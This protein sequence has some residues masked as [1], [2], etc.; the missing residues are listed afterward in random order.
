[1]DDSDWL[2]AVLGAPFPTSARIRAALR[3]DLVA[4]WEAQHGPLGTVADDLTTMRT[5]FSPLSKSLTVRKTL[6]GLAAAPVL[7]QVPDPPLV[8]FGPDGRPLVS[9]E[10]RVAIDVLATSDQAAVLRVVAQLAATQRELSRHRLHQVVGDRADTGKPAQ[11][12]AI[13]V[14]IVM[15]L[16]GNVGEAAALPRGD[17]TA[18]EQAVARAVE[19]FASVVAPSKRRTRQAGPR[20]LGGW[21]LGELTRRQD[22]VVFRDSARLYLLP[23]GE[24]AAAARAGGLLAR[25][26]RLTVARLG[27]GLDALGDALRTEAP[28]MADRGL[29]VGDEDRHAWVRRAVLAG[30]QSGRRGGAAQS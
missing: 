25:R 18:V 19:A 13:G 17:D 26:K 2:T 4:L 23:D 8:E 5:L 16:N 10:G 9:P 12:P 1:M 14:L 7:E 3:D 24:R 6:A 29:P 20:P 21:E 30:F 27:D 28:L 11:V 15:L 22:D